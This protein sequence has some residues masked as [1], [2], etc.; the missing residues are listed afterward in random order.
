MNMYTW[1][2]ISNIHMN[3][4]IH[5]WATWGMYIHMWD[6]THAYIRDEFCIVRFSPP[7]FPREM[8]PTSDSFIRVTW[9]IHM[10]DM[11]HSFVCREVSF[12]NVLCVW[13]IHTC[14]VTH[15]CVRH[16]S[17]MCPTWLLSCVSRGLLYV[18]AYVRLHV[19]TYVTHNSLLIPRMNIHMRGLLYVYS[20]V[21]HESCI[22]MRNESHVYMH[23]SYLVYMNN[24]LLMY[25]YE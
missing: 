9:L 10:W 21:R 18:Y 7:F 11:T 17:Y 23:E 1:I 20:Y 13:L 22:Y 5:M 2:C 25:V 6:M 3:I 12:G 19:Y 16:D 15:T 8:C 24:D 4:Y 14:D